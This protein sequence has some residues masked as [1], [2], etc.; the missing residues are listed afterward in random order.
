MKERI[1]QQNDS[2]DIV[3][4]FGDMCLDF[5]RW[6]ILCYTRKEDTIDDSHT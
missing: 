2:S 3:C 4:S 5:H 1:M 6:N